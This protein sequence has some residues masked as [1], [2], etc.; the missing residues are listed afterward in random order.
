MLKVEVFLN[1]GKKIYEIKLYEEE[2]GHG[3]LKI[4]QSV[5]GMCNIY[6]MCVIPDYF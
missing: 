6:T 5:C 4:Q 3:K 1:S 2:Y